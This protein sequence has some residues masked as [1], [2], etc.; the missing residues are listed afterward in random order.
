MT[1]SHNGITS[2]S[3]QPVAASASNGSFAFSTLGFSNA[4][5]VTFGTSAGSI[6]TA[7]VASAGAGTTLSGFQ[8]YADQ[9]LAFTPF[10]QNFI[11]IAPI[12]MPC[13]V[14]FDRICFPISVAQNAVNSTATM[15]MWA[16]FYT[17]NASTLSLAHSI[18]TN[19][20]FNLNNQSLHNGYRVA[21]IAWTSTIPAGNYCVGIMT[22]VSGVSISIS[23]AGASHE[24]IG[25]NGL[26]FNGN[27][28]ASSNQL[29]IGLGYQTATTTA[30]PNAI[31]FSDMAG[32]QTFAN[33][34]QVFYL[35]SGTA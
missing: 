13:A 19:Y 31:A 10:G 3:V 15:S 22:A 27:S 11:Q 6:L 17:K 8:P 33:R 7:S 12:D 2:Q 30:L 9:A 24:N 23:N 18:S 25:Y 26:L 16:A 35:T 21:T 1:A 14:Q 32:S 20:T 29:T 5:G 28:T 34:P 4:N